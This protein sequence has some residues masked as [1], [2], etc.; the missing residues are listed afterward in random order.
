MRIEASIEEWRDLYQVAIKLKKLKPWEDLWDMDLITILPLGK[1]EP[2]ICSVMGKGGEFYGIG[3][4]IG[5]KAINDFFTIADNNDIP[6]NQLIRY[7][8]NIMC[9]FGSRDELTKKELNIIKELGLKFRGKNDWVYFR[10]YEKGY[11]PYMPDKNEVLEITDILK[12]LY[13]AIKSLHNGL[14]VDFENGKTLM[15]CF[16]KESNLWLN[17]EMPLLIPHIHYAVPVLEDQLL[18][19][20]LKNKAKNNSVLELDIAYLNSVINDKSYDKPIIPRLCILADKRSGM[21][22]SQNM[23]APEDDEIDAMFGAVINYIL[24]AGRPERIVVREKYS[25]SI[26][27]DLCKQTGIDVMESGKLPAIDDFIEAFYEY[28]N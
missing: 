11:A 9:N 10:V 20:R 22:L 4:Y 19:K 1:D 18:M 23:V 26:I 14:K 24:Q 8:N 21:L 16:H 25:S 12:H 28:R 3:I 2:C 17:Y 27:A 13:M 15:R 6:Q 5:G 7:Q